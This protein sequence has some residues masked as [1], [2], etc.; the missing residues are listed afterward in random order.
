MSRKSREAPSHLAF[1]VHK[2]YAQ[3]FAEIRR[4]LGLTNSAFLRRAIERFVA[5][6]VNPSLAQALTEA[7]HGYRA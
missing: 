7:H 6:E 5:T 1:R 3:L 2:D 4:D